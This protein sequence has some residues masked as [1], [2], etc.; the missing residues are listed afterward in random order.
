[1]LNQESFEKS[2]WF[3][4]F[5]IN[6]LFVARYYVS[7]LDKKQKLM[8]HL[9]PSASQNLNAQPFVFPHEMW[10]GLTSSLSLAPHKNDR[11]LKNTW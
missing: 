5:V 7:L 11:K 4:K 10:N 2:N 3:I 1:M 8:M 9:L 6:H